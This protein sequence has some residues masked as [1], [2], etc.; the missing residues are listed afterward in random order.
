[1]E[2]KKPFI[3]SSMRL[4]L[5]DTNARVGGGLS[6]SSLGAAAGGMAGL[7]LAVRGRPRAW[8]L[9]SRRP[10][11]PQP[12]PDAVNHVRSE[13]GVPETPGCADSPPRLPEL[14][15][16]VMLPLTVYRRGRTQTTISRGKGRAG[17]GPGG[18]TPPSPRGDAGSKVTARTSVANQG[19]PALGVQGLYLAPVTQT[20]SA[21]CVADLSPQP[22][23]RPS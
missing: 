2:V 12:A 20:W 15:R 16:A 10:G 6:R 19:S 21:A 13:P 1:M 14:T 7:A 17:Q 22:L 18:S 3:L 9:L 4:P 23:G 8:V 11:L 5:L